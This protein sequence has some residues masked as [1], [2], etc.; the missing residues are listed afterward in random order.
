[1]TLKNLDKIK[2]I[3]KK[4]KIEFKNHQPPYR[5]FLH[6]IIKLCSIHEFHDQSLDPMPSMS[7]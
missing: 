3:I 1:M 6:H 7:N 4:K 5:L 2:S